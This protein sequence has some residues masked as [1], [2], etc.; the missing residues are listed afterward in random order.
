MDRCAVATAARAPAEGLKP[1]PAV[2][3]RQGT[4]KDLGTKRRHGGAQA[5]AATQPASHI[6]FA[7][8][9]PR[10]ELT[11][12]A[13]APFSGIEPKHNF[14]QRNHVPHALLLR[15]DGEFCHRAKYGV[16]TP[17]LGLVAAQK[18]AEDFHLLVALRQREH[19]KD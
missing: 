13:Y 10:F 5:E 9:F 19:G 1:K 12:G 18:L 15:L 8:A 11:G 6:I 16:S 4:S 17:H 3:I 2:L 7:P 14:A